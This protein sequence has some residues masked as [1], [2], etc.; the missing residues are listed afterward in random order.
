[1]GSATTMTD[2]MLKRIEEKVYAGERVTFD[3]GLYLDEQ[4]DLM[5]LGR[6]AN[7]VRERKNGNF[8]YYN[9]NVHLNPTNVCVYRCRFCAFRADLK[10]EK[11]YV[12]SEPM[13]K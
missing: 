1:M 2:G 10:A 11:A 7:H 12:F 8:A 6:L 13:L 5:A 4:A 9:T 3:E